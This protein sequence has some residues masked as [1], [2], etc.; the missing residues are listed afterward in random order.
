MDESSAYWRI[1]PEELSCEV[2]AATSKDF[3]KLVESEDFRLDWEMTNLVEVARSQLGN[4]EAGWVFHLIIPALFHGPYEAS[5]FGTAPLE[6][7]IELS[8]EWSL[9]AKDVPEG[10]HVLLPVTE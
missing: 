6:E 8:G 5:N 4:L 9:T 2:V 7:L 1:C 3:F 10:G